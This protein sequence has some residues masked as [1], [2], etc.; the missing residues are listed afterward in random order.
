MPFQDT[1]NQTDPELLQELKCV[2][3]EMQKQFGENQDIREAIAEVV[4]MQAAVEK[5]GPMIPT[6]RAQVRLNLV[7][8]KLTIQANK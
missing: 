1:N 2:L 4:V 6:D 7:E 8:L 3:E 5:G